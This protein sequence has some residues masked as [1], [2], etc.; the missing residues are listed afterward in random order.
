MLLNP[1]E[2]PD[3]IMFM[4]NPDEFIKQKSNKK[5]TEEKKRIFKM[6]SQTSKGARRAPVDDKG[7]DIKGK[8]FDEIELK[9]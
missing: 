2:A 4:M 3:L 1:E 6:V 9:D 5:V 7:N 8:I